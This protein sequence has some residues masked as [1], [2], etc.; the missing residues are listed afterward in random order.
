MLQPCD[1]PHRAVPVPPALCVL[2]KVWPDR[3]WWELFYIC[4]RCCTAEVN[5]FQILSAGSGNHFRCLE[6]NFVCVASRETDDLTQ[7]CRRPM[8]APDVAF[9]IVCQASHTLHYEAAFYLLG[10]V[11]GEGRFAN[12][13]LLC[14]G[15]CGRMTCHPPHTR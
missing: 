13:G 1:S 7:L 15:I 6:H 14:Q 2:A 10:N 12:C 3:K 11:E 5:N 8:S 9:I 4:L